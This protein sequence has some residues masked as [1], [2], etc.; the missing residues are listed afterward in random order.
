MTQDIS[1][2]TDKGLPVLIAS[3]AFLALKYLRSP[4][5]QVLIRFVDPKFMM[6]AW[7]DWAKNLAVALSVGT[8]AFVTSKLQGDATAHSFVMAL[9]GLLAM[10]HV[11]GKPDVDSIKVDIPDPKP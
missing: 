4:V 8:S 10:L 3:L 11:D 7:P 1:L 5:G 9:T 2:V 6:A